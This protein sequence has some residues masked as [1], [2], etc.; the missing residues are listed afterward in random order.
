MK[1]PDS[2]PRELRFTA[3]PKCGWVVLMGTT[4]MDNCGLASKAPEL[5]GL[6]VRNAPL[7]EL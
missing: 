4:Y 6:F 7:E 2:T 5:P 3:P 1:H